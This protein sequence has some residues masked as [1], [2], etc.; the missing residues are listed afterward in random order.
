MKIIE[1]TPKV[2]KTIRAAV[3]GQRKSICMG[4]SY[5]SA[6]A[7]SGTPIIVTEADSAPLLAGLPYLK[8][9]FVGRGGF[10]KTLYTPSTL[11]IEVGARWIAA[12]A[13]LK[14]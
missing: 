9:N 14:N 4:R 3:R 1:I 8:T 12:Q 5:N 13:S 6:G 11:R 10:R 2:A 7:G